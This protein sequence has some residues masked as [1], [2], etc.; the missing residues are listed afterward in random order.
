[1]RAVEQRLFATGVGQGAL[2]ERAGAAIAEQVARLAAGRPVLVLAGPGNN[3]GDGYVAARLLF[4][5]G[6]SAVVAAMGKPKDG[7]AEYMAARWSAPVDDMRAAEPRP[8]LV[9]ALLGI[10]TPR[11]FDPETRA[12]LARLTA[13]ADLC[14]AVD[15][16]SGRHADTGEGEGEADVTI[17]L[18]ALKP[19]HVVG[20]GADACGHVLLADLGVSRTSRAST[21][22]RPTLPAWPHDVNKFSRGMV[23][24]V[25]GAMPGAGWLAGRAALAAGAGYVQLVGLAPAD[26]APRALVRHRIAC[27]GDM[28][29]VLDDPRIGTVVI[30]PGLGRDDA[31]RALL[32]AALASPHDLVIDGDAL[33]LLGRSIGDRIATDRRRVCL[34]PHG[35]EFARMFDTA[36]DK[37]SITRAAARKTGATVVN[38]GPDTVIGYPDGRIVVSAGT[39]PGLSTAGTGDLLAG[40]IA[41]RMAAGP[42]GSDAVAAGVWLHARAADHMGAIFPADALPERLTQE[43]NR[44]PTR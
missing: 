24:I 13:A 40:T 34:T 6:V 43:V 22:S 32:D 28:S 9:D 19:A 42:G 21:I 14:I 27:V 5:R 38:K 16:P 33:T 15:V 29:S 1:M 12:A 23:A 26:G 44:C 30:G 39:N 35:G 37:L 31:A 2:M 25:S 8:V 17:A 41:A 18:G 20:A 7:A 11:P 3:G 36:G 10:G 4:E